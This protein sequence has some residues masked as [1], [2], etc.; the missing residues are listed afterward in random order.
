LSFHVPTSSLCASAM[1]GSIMD[2]MANKENIANVVNG[3]FMMFLLKTR[4]ILW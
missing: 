2:A 4:H 1:R 3:R